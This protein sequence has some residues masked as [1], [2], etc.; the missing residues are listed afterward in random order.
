[1]TAT[2]QKVLSM[3]SG[4]G[5]VVITNRP[6]WTKAARELVALGVLELVGQ[7]KD[8]EIRHGKR[9]AYVTTTYQISK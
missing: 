4:N 6:G 1:M 2:Q 3:V 7:D 9:V 5:R 8:V